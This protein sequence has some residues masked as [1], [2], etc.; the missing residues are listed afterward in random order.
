MQE[1]RASVVAIV[2]ERGA[3]KSTFVTIVKDFL[4]HKKVESV[5]YS[6][7][8][9]QILTILNKQI[10]REHLSTLITALRSA[11]GDEGILT[12]AIRQHIQRLDA[13][14]ILIDGVRKA[15][16]VPLIRELKGALVYITA[17]RQTRF[18]RRRADR[19]NI[20][21][22]GMSWETFMKLDQ[23]APEV[24]IRQIGE[25]MADVTIDNSGTVEEF[26][27]SV[28]SFIQNHSLN[29]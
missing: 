22:F 26:K 21:E 28:D 29:G 1:S 24:T 27:S 4:R 10:T 9:R 25:T 5:K 20:D 18:E 12:D 19:E 15:E 23:L 11:F 16:E 13:D 3:G 8:L 7:P 6:D 17:D 14:V 2:A